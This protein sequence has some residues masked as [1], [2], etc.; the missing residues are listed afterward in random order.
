MKSA[1][2]KRGFWPRAT[3]SIKHGMELLSSPQ[4]IAVRCH[5]IY[6]LCNATMLVCSSAVEAERTA[7]VCVCFRYAAFAK[8]GWRRETWEELGSSILERDPAE[9]GS[10]S[11]DESSASETEDGE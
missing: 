6:C 5:D 7:L 2:L 11:D 4:K 9:Y 3:A 8:L 10:S 1:A